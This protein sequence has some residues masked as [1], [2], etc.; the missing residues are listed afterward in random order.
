MT[1]LL[2]KTILITGVASGIGARTAELA[3][4]LGADVIG[5]D[6]REPTVAVG[7]FVKADISSRAGVDDLVAS[8][9]QRIDALCN[10]AGL[11]GNTGAVSTLAVNFYGLR[12]LSE[13]LAPK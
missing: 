11:S 9:P 4:Q 13:G 8:M 5:V 2:G 7:S 3:G 12:A 6:M 1:M 10:V